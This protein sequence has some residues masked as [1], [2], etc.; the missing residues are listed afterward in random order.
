MHLKRQSLSQKGT[1]VFL[2]G[3]VGGGSDSKKTQIH[4]QETMQCPKGVIA[5][6]VSGTAAWEA[7]G[8]RWSDPS[9]L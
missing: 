3:G 6:Y 4:F 5:D 9:R 1:S 2:G 8:V 7:F